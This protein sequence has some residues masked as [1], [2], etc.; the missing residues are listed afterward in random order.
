MK[1]EHNF[2]LEHRSR[3]KEITF[4]GKGMEREV[5]EKERER[6]KERKR[7]KQA[8]E[9]RASSTSYQGTF[10]TLCIITWFS[11]SFFLLS[12]R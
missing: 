12:P 8:K 6:E 7:E 4:K 9:E 11:L 10:C 3:I 2:T 5:R 1:R